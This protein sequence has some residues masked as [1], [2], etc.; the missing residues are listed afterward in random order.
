MTR[1]PPDPSSPLAALLAPRLREAG[2]DPPQAAPPEPIASLAALGRHPLHPMLIHFP[3][4]ALVGLVGADAALWFS[5]DPFWARAGLWLAGVG[6]FGGWIAGLVGMIDLLAVAR[7]REKITA[8]SHALV[9]VMLLSL[10]S[11]NWLLRYRG[12]ISVETVVAGTGLSLLG[13]VL[14]GLAGRLGSRLVYEQAV[15]VQH[16]DLPR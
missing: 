14:I 1:P 2:V 7:I 10:A 15:G 9:A 12:E 13:A 6:A 4:A 11:L 3:I 5:G 16:P 8:W